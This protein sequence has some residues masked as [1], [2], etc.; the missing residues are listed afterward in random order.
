MQL[1]WCNAMIDE[2]FCYFIAIKY[3]YGDYYCA[4]AFSTPAATSLLDWQYIFIHTAVQLP[5]Q[6]GR[7]PHSIIFRMLFVMR[8]E[9]PNICHVLRL[10]WGY[11]GMT[12]IMMRHM[13]SS[14]LQTNTGMEKMDV[15]CLVASSSWIMNF[16]WG[17]VGVVCCWSDNVFKRKSDEWVGRSCMMKN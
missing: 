9:K 3:Y 1:C 2:C 15:Q 12:C 8:N 10:I 11:S 7:Q 16:L 6:E 5:D 17:W 14:F 13:N 4:N